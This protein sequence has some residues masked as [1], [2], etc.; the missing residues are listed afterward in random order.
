[1][2]I[3]YLFLIVGIIADTTT[4]YNYSSYNSSR[5]NYPNAVQFAYNNYE[6]LLVQN[7]EDSSVLLYYHGNGLYNPNEFNMNNSY[8][9]KHG[10]SNKLADIFSYCINSAVLDSGYRVKLFNSF[11]NTTDE[12]SIALCSTDGGSL[13]ATN[14]II[15]TES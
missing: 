7:E 14:T 9:Y 12:G 3:I 8:L 6:N 13:S 1:M 15:V 4:S 2:K 11:I 5:I 10:K